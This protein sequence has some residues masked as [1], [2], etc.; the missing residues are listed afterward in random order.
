MARLAS[1]GKGGWYPAAPEAVAAVLERMRPPHDGDC[2]VIDPCCGRAD[3]LLQLAAGLR[4]IPYGIELSEDRSRIAHDV[5]PDGQCL[6]PADFIR[7][8]ISTRSFS[9]A[10]TNPPY[11]F[12][13][14]NEGRVEIA[15]LERAAR[16]LVHDGVMCLVAPEDVCA[17]Y[18]MQRFFDSHFYQ[19]SAMPFPES[20]RKYNETIIM[21]CKRKEPVD[22]PWHGH[23]LEEMFGRSYTYTLPKGERPKTW[24]KSEPTDTEVARLVVNSPLRFAL[25]PP[26]DKLDYRPRP[27]MSIGVGHRALLLASGYIDGLIQPRGERPHVLRGTATKQEYIS[28]STTEE[29]SEGNVTTRTVT[30][31]RPVLRIRVLDSYGEIHNLE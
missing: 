26:T 11:N 5:L 29:D 19:V 31:E 16:L 3:A 24:R 23:W 13:V 22:P 20:G 28:A 21:G 6:A 14:G 10:W 15:F 25:D 9:M 2:L 4:A 18:A 8:Q 27:P 17:G 30:S 12:A 7:T 1:E